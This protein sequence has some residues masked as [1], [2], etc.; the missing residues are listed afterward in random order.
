MLTAN[1]RIAASITSSRKS[2]RLLGR[3]ARVVAEALEHRMLLSASLS[4]TTL[5]VTGTSAADTFTLSDDGTTITVMQDAASSTFPDSSVDS[6]IV[7]PTTGGDTVNL[8]SNTKPVSIIGGGLDTV[9]IGDAGLLAQIKGS[10]NVS[11]PTSFTNLNVDG[12]AADLASTDFGGGFTDSTISR[13]S[14]GTISYTASQLS[15]L[16]LTT[17]NEVDVYSTGIL[18]GNVPTVVNQLGHAVVQ[19]WTTAG[20]LTINSQVSNDFIIVGTGGNAQNIQGQ[21]VLN[22]TQ[23]FPAFALDID[24]SLDTVGRNIVLSRPNNTLRI[25]G[26]TP[27]D[28]IDNSKIWSSALTIDAGSGNDTINMG[29]GDH[30]K[31][32]TING[33]AGD[34]TFIVPNGYYNF[35]WL[36]LYGDDG[37]DHFIDDFAQSFPVTLDGGAGDNTALIDGSS[38]NTGEQFNI[39]A[40]ATITAS[41]PASPNPYGGVQISTTA[42]QQIEI[43][44]S[45]FNDTVTADPALTVPLLVH[46][47]AGNDSITGG[48]ANDSLFGDAGND[49]LV[50]GAGSDSLNGGVGTDVLSGGAGIDTLDGGEG[51]PIQIIADNLANAPVNGSEGVTLTGNWIPSTSNSG[52]YGTN[53]FTDNNTF[54]GSKSIQ[55]TPQIPTTG[56]YQVYARWPASTNRAT[57]T[58]FTVTHQG[59]ASTVIENQQ[60]HNNAWVL[61]GTYTLSAGTSSSVTISNTNTNGYVIADAVRFVPVIATASISGTVF[62]DAN[63]NGRQNPGEAGVANRVVYIDSNKDGILDDGEP[64]TTTDAAGNWSLTG[65]AA[66]AYRIREQNVA[67]VRHTDPPG[68]ANYY[69]LTVTTGSTA[70][71]IYGKLFGETTVLTT[72]APILAI[73]AGGPAFILNSG[74]TYATD[75]NFTGGAATT[76]VFDVAGTDNDPIYYSYRSGSSFSYSLPVANG[77]YKLVLNFVDPTSTAAGQRKFNVTAEGTQVL[78]NFDIVAAAGRKTAISK[79]FTVT[80]TN[81]TL[82]ISLKPVVGSAILSGI[83]LY[84]A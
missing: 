41:T 39:D 38:L 48:A 70:S 78:T 76:T 6:I 27:A 62:N 61:L 7:N 54:K 28:I 8:Q 51:Q 25:H 69:D 45:A 83:V 23:N 22:S 9:N 24:D 82:T 17:L 80:V 15:G 30:E 1:H 66:G 73:N 59:I 81:G 40:N 20:P 55:F 58:P 14:P 21:V 57:N 37:N 18:H 13:F 68:N 77:T 50:A 53:Y 11:N 64:S 72:P 79:A 33:G 31:Y 32:C 2:T 19:V 34:D 84:P 42:V 16:T 4:G 29:S 5:N 46:G 49:T 67:G 10:V 47:G 3:S 60:I 44:A 65:L 74:F 71:A 12:S 43:V 56:A 75:T 63:A 36:R 26:A 52:F 35:G